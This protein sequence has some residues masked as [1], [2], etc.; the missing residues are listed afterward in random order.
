ME[1]D[2]QKCCRICLDV[3]NEHVS[4]LGDPTIHLH[5]K[6]C[7][8]IRVVS[9]DDLPKAICGPCANQLKEYYN[10]Q[11]TARCSQDF[12]E[13][14]VQEKSRKSTETKTPI[15]PLPDSEYNSDSLLEFLNNTA[16]IEEYLNNLGKEDIPSIV[17]F[18]D[19]N[20]KSM[21]AAKPK[22]PT[23]KKKEAVAII[24]KAD[25]KMEIDVLDSDVDVVKEILMKGTEPKIKANP[26][27]NMKVQVKTLDKNNLTCFA[28][29]VKF[30]N[31][32]KLSQHLSTCDIAS[33][34]CFHCNMLFD[35]KQKMQQHFVT[36]NNAF[37]SMC[38]CGM[39][40]PSRE[41]LT[42]HHKTCHVDYGAAMGCSYRCKEC[43]EIFRERWVLLKS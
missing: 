10:F 33:R 2:I 11:L 18:L 38:S 31:I 20:E 5:L 23:P 34:T 32:H 39:Q 12:L 14:A 43:G 22:M 35:S 41:K 6:S 16:N 13:S 19:R 27:Q 30:D 28:C 3:E 15:Q 36:H 9:S 17:N 8:G 7:L 26:N 40:F 4:I 42:Q 24:K 25:M 29:E 21:S 1:G 37:P